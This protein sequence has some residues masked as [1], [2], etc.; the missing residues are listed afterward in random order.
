MTLTVLGGMAEKLN[1]LVAGAVKH[2]STRV[3]VQ[4]RGSALGE[5]FGAPLSVSIVDEIRRLPYVDAAFPTLYMLYQEADE[6]L[7]PL[8]L[9]IPFLVVGMSPDHLEYEEQRHPVSLAA[10]RFFRAEEQNV[11]VVGSNFAKAKNLQLGT[12]L[13]VQGRRLEVIGI[14]D[15]ALTAQDSIVYTPLRTA[16]ELLA[17]S[18]P[19]PFNHV[20]YELASQVEVYATDLRWADRIAEAINHEVKGTRALAPSQIEP[21][22]RQSLRIFNA[23]A[24][25]S[26][27]IA[28]V[29]GGM[30]IFNIMMMSVYER[31]REIGVKKA[32]GATNA[33]I[34]GE[35]LTEA[36]VI[37]LIGAILGVMAGALVVALVNNSAFGRGVVIFAITRRLILLSLAFAALISGAS[38]L[39]PALRAARLRPVE[40]LRAQ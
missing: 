22:F 7:P 1:F 40:A 12:A 16:Q 36:L 9:G 4:P 37:G 32:V 30:S 20:P 19:T 14:M 11:A 6:D 27:I 3:I 10:G 23:I 29:V 8:G 17:K 33:D 31:T 18:L 35:F 13:T 5:L 28:V 38:G 2:Y 34:A 15:Q 26:A 21:Q 39:F 24:I 25:G